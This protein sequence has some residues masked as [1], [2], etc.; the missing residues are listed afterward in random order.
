MARYPDWEVGDLV[1]ADLLDAMVPQ[2]FTKTGNTARTSTT[3]YAA[4]PDLQS[5]PLGVGT[6]DI[7][8]VG[9]FTLDTT[10]TQK[11]KVQWGF[12]GTWTTVFRACIGPGQGATNTADGLDTMNSRG[13]QTDADSATY[14]INFG[15]V[16][17]VFR[18]VARN[19][20]VSVAGNLSLRWAQAASSANAT[21]L[22]AGSHFI[23]RQCA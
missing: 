11:I 6:W 14:D 9:F 13:A 22:L 1:T 19:V 18:E 5:I 12:T 2:I 10:S 21:N 4:D 17:G 7:E 8:F 16:P 20:V 23:I 3:T 15:S